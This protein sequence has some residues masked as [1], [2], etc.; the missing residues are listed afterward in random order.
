MT[1]H[2]QMGAAWARFVAEVEKVAALR[3]SVASNLEYMKF[4]E[5]GPKFSSQAPEG[6]VRVNREKHAEMVQEELKESLSDTNA[7]SFARAV[8]RGL[9]LAALRVM[10]H[11]SDVTP[12]DT[13]RA[14]NSWFA[15]LPNGKQVNVDGSSPE[16]EQ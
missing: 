15:I 3:A 10:R 9:S 1:A 16:G 7:A 8:E 14:K 4:L 11:V 13:G 12:V 2:N 6:M 5:Y